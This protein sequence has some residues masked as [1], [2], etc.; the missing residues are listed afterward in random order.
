M[1]EE[2]F[3]RETLGLHLSSVVRKGIARSDKATMTLALRV[4]NLAREK[5]VEGGSHKPGSHTTASSGRGPAQVS[6][7]LRA[8]LDKE[9]VSTTTGVL[10][11]RVGTKAT[12]RRPY[13]N[14]E[15][16]Q[17][18]VLMGRRKKLGTGSNTL[19]STVGAA[20]ELRKKGAR[21]PFLKPAYDEGTKGLES[22]FRASFAEGDWH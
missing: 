18:G 21:Y 20:L 6:G 22:T 19:N 9:T 1:I 15:R 16:R 12:E 7:Q 13:A 2:P 10:T 8:S 14:S 4:L 3:S 11:I 17:A 5:V